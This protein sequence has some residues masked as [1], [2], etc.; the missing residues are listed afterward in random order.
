MNKSRGIRGGGVETTLRLPKAD[1]KGSSKSSTLDARLAASELSACERS[2]SLKKV[3]VPFEFGDWEAW[4]RSC[5]RY[6]VILYLSA[7]WPALGMRRSAATV[8]V[9]VYPPEN[10]TQ[11]WKHWYEDGAD[12]LPGA[13]PSTSPTIYYVV[14]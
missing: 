14:Q 7:S 9:V 6:T 4:L 8:V 1:R 3:G 10:M 2:T 12:G 13:L 5:H 11:R